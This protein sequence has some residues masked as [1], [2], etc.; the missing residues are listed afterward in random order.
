[1]R[2]PVE[3]L[4]LFYW[5]VGEA[6]SC[7]VSCPMYSS[8]ATFTHKVIQRKRFELSL[9]QGMAQFHMQGLHR[10]VCPRSGTTRT[11]RLRSLG[12]GADANVGR[13][14]IMGSLHP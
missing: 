2:V 13:S 5:S 1:M 7:D 10:E 9:G 6:L 8:G 12:F 4:L 14:P 3:R 11:Q